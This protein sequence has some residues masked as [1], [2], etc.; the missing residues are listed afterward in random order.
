[1]PGTDGFG[2]Q[3]VDSIERREYTLTTTTRVSH[4]SVSPDRFRFPID[5]GVRITTEAITL[6]TVVPIYVRD[7]TGDIVA[8][9]EHFAN[10]ELSA[11]T[12]SLEVCAPI[13]LY[14][15][16]TSPVTVTADATQTHVTFGGKT[17]V[18]VGARSDHQRPAATITTT[19]DVEDMMAAISAL[20]SSLKTTSPERS[21]PTL[22]GHPPTIELGDQLDIPSGLESP[23]TGVRLE[24]PAE[25]RSLYVASPLAYYLGATLT[26]GSEPR[27]VTDTGFEYPLGTTDDFE[28]A[29]ERL[30]KQVFFL[31]CVTRTEGYYQI[32]LHERRAIESS[33]DLDFAALYDRPLADRLEAYLS[34]PFDALAEQIPGWKLTT[35]VSPTPESIELL[36]FMIDNL[37]IVRTPESTPVAESNVQSVTVDEF[38]RDTAD[39]FTRS[40]GAAERPMSSYV[41]PESTESIEQSWIGDGLPIGA[42]KATSEAFQHRLNRTP[43]EGDITITVVCNDPEM[44]AERDAI[45]RVYGS[46]ET[47]PFDVTLRHNVTIEE[48]RRELASSAEFLHY[49]GHID[50]RGFECADG[51]LDA[52]T[53]DTVNV[54]AFLLNACQSYQQ[55]MHLIEAGS[56]GGVVTLNEVINSGAVRIGRA[57]ARLLNRGFPLQP[58]LEIARDESIV[59]GQ[60]TV[61]GDGSLAITQAESGI[62][63]LCTIESK[64]D[65][66]NVTSRT[67]PTPKRG[68][69]T[70]VIPYLKENDRYFLGFGE[71]RKFD[72][73]SDELY[74]FLELEDIPVKIDGELRWSKQLDIDEL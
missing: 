55:G 74:E 1:V 57:M 53:L 56:I 58:A 29:I 64:G 65:S 12:Y 63:N 45:D 70:T 32:D 7:E 36:P 47:L 21:Y 43:T 35:H 26:P 68:M 9:A 39:A 18:L 22:R 69:G 30:L 31:D 4:T 34:V 20:G 17:E 6:P 41:R 40:A 71:M 54:D 5:A 28:T 38:F 49:I 66:F 16:V 37:A 14:L 8:E 10:E 72:L 19:T 48:L 67:Y 24:V 61:V 13:K 3:I 50:A 60:Y 33:V 51:M 46:R 27:L 11:G 73:S 15:R 2:L 25:Y 42:S 23:D 44:G 59:G 52:A 62:P